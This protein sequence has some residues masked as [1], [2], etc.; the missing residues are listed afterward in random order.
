MRNKKG[1]IFTNLNE[2]RLL[3]DRYNNDLATLYSEL[4]NNVVIQKIK[5]LNGTEEVL[6]NT[7]SFVEIYTKIV[8][9]INNIN[10]LSSEINKANNEIECMPG[11]TIQNALSSLKSLRTLRSNLS[12]IYT[13]NSFKQ[14]KSDVNG[15]SYYLIQ[16]L[17]FDKEWLQKEINRIS[18]E[19]DRYE[20]AILKANNEAQI[21][22]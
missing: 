2:A 16:E 3:L 15:S 8:E 14:R 13:C 11:V 18:E 20:A 22:F 5:E 7:K 17:N 9:L 6:S 10:K 12:A 19:I 4:K 21:E 1:G